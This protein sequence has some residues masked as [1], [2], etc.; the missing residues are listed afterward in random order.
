MN[1][2]KIILLGLLAVSFTAILAISYAQA[3]TSGN[4]NNTVS[5]SL[6][7][8]NASNN[9]IIH[10]VNVIPYHPRDPVAYAAEKKQLDTATLSWVKTQSSAQ[11][12]GLFNAIL[13]PVNI[14]GSG[15]NGLDYTQCNC[16]P[17]D[18][19]VAI[20]P[21][22]VF[23]M[24]NVEGQTYDRQGNLNQTIS[25]YTLFHFS[26]AHLLSDPKILFDS[27]SGRWFASAL[28]VSINAV[29]IA[30]S[31]TSDPSVNNWYV[32]QE[33]YGSECPDQPKIGVSDDKFVVSSNDFS[34]HCG[35]FNNGTSS[36]DGAEY[37]V[38]N[39]SS[40]LSGT[41]SVY[42]NGPNVSDFAVT[43]IQS[44]SST[45]TLYMVSD[46]A[47]SSTKQIRVF[48]ITGQVPSIS[49]NTNTVTLNTNIL[50][51][52]DALQPVTSTI[53]DTGDTRI[54]NAV[55]NH[56]K[57]WFGLTDGCTPTG[58]TIQRSCARL[59]QINT[60]TTSVIQDFDINAS[61]TYYYYPALQF[62]GFGGIGTVI[63][64]SN[65][66][67]YPSLKV[68]GQAAQDPAKTFKQLL[69]L[70]AGSNYYDTTPYGQDGDVRYGDYFGAALDPSNNTRV[71]LAGEYITNA[72]SH[73]NNPTWSTFIGSI[74]FDCVP[75]PTG[76]WT[77]TASCTLGG[78]AT[79]HANVIVQNNALLTIPNKQTLNIDFTH[80]HL[81][82]KSGSGVFIAAGGK[83]S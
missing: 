72:P 71:W 35:A 54:D 37:R 73:N 44:M 36:N 64:M 17:P 69:Y 32:D 83:I 18:V 27:Q 12:R 46:G 75:P 20:G 5:S 2:K 51:P 7:P 66:T 26:T 24:V 42:K 50:T 9:S 49:I 23:E 31:K 65:S 74:T 22:N 63:G 60:N 19:Q 55:W 21:G 76:D 82:V 29:G 25:L 62:D 38:F 28:D 81:L 3:Q 59:I 67:I 45:T 30:V 39:K 77:I 15:F 4:S 78:N 43:P 47:V 34:N 8:S 33:S 41:F 52:A 6:V 13:S 53:L 58:D 48:S 79:A 14:I 1:S 70:K 57:L 56:G 68:T 11:K 10:S 40:M 80:N 16:E 61:A